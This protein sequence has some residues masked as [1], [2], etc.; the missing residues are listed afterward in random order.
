MKNPLEEDL[1]SAVELNHQMLKYLTDDQIYRI[2]HYLGK[3]TVQNILVFRF[4]NMI[5]EPVWNRESIDHVQITLA[6][7]IGIE[8][9]AGYFE[10][11]G[12]LRD[13]LQNH[14][15]QLLA[16]IAMEQPF[17]MDAADIMDEKFKVFK[18]IEPFKPDKLNET[19]IR[20]Q[21]T[22]G[23]IAGNSVSAYRD[24]NGVDKNSCTETFFS[25]KFF[26]NNKRWKGVPF[27]LRSGK[28]LPKK[29]TI[30][31][32]VFKEVPDCLFCKL[33]ILHQPNILTFNIQPE[34]GVSL[35][36][37]A[38][39]PG[40][41]MCLSALDMEFDYKSVFGADTGGDYET[42]IQE[43]MLG[44]QT[45]FW[46]K[47][48]IEESWKLLTPVLKAW[49]ECPLDEKSR[50]MHFYPA[51]SWGPSEADDFIK[52]DGREWIL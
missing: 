36:F 32:I 31:N 27:Y 24:E 19:I 15:M 25:A 11:A 10:K 13:M 35:K 22:A 41:K 3:N 12:L 8:N 42:I 29:T 14:M 39:V 48:G 21:Y 38:K 50:I 47:D 43:C 49:E 17:S 52:K 18:A 45:L 7:D 20:G 9:R 33:G 37:T 6:E 34:Q 16:I 2:D 44:D 28:R 1:E 46:R 4:A 5:F 30:I 26:I 23:Q 51:G 40:S